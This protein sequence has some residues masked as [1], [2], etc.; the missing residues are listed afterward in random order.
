LIRA[1]GARARRELMNEDV[2]ASLDDIFPG[3]GVDAPDAYTWE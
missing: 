3:L 2:L 1:S